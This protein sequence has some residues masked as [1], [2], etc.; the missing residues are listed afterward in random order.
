[1]GIYEC[2]T[3]YNIALNELTPNPD[4]PRKVFS[5]DEIKNLADSI[6]DKGL[7][8]PILVK[9]LEDGQIIIVS[10]ERRFRAHQFLKRE[11]I[12]AWFTTGDAE[13]LALVENLVRE[14]LSAMETAE[15]LKK[16]ADRFG[17][18]T[19][20]DL[21]KIIGKASNT[22]SEILSLN[23]LS[24]NIRIKVRGDKRFALRELKKI[25]TKRTLK[26]QEKLFSAYAAKIEAESQEKATRSRLK[27]TDLHLKKIQSMQ[28]Y[29]TKMAAA[30]KFQKLRSLSNEMV[31]LKM[32]IENIL[33]KFGMLNS[34][35]D[36]SNEVEE[37]Y[38]LKMT[39]RLD[40]DTPDF[41]RKKKKWRG[42]DS[43]MG[44]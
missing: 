19:H 41:D 40:F 18:K 21:G 8:Q 9:K 38:G 14:D 31:D 20:G 36:A 11:T 43:S 28:E 33:N 37:S 32:S 5:E 30:D 22:V 1:M 23:D 16:L 24:E 7:L 2:G 17:D 35:I 42:Y 15:A 12:P 27:G 26:A 39:S 29:F 25:A 10:G 4:Q 13:E 44:E 3:L 34:K 6:N